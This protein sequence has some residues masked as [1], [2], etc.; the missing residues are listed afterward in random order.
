MTGPEHH[1]E[2]QRLTET[3]REYPGASDA[4]AGGK[5]GKK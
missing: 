3:V 4:P 1:T 5:G 2:A